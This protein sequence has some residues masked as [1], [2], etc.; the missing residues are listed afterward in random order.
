MP[1]EEVLFSDKAACKFEQ[2]VLS[3]KWGEKK[4]RIHRNVPVAN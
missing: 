3:V 1:N 4:L 2:Q